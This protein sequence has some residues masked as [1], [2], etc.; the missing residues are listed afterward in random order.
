MIELES[1]VCVESNYSLDA[2]SLLQMARGRPSRPDRG[3]GCAGM[4]ASGST[5]ERAL[6]GGGSGDQTGTEPLGDACTQHLEA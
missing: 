6:S 4:E 3:S 2:V 1:H 5:R